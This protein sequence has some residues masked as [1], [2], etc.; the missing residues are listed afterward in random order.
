MRIGALRVHAQS[1][2]LAQTQAWICATDRSKH[3]IGYRS[4]AFAIEPDGFEYVL[5]D[6]HGQQCARR[7]EGCDVESALVSDASIWR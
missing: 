7:R 3:L 2:A 5:H 4:D 6:A 1:S